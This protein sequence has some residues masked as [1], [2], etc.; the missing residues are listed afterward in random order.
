MS[1]K[2]KELMRV[3]LRQKDYRTALYY[4][5]KIDEKEN[6]TQRRKRQKS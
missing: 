4:Q 1:N 3:A 6:E 2:Y 5:N